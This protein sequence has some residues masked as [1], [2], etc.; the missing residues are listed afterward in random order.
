VTLG[1]WHTI[2]VSRAGRAGTLTLDGQ[3]TAT[4]EGQSKGLF[5][6]LTLRQQLFVGGY[7]DVNEITS[8]AGLNQSFHGCIQRV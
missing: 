1:Q 4:V 6:Q 7:D 2:H 8:I 3:T 5:T